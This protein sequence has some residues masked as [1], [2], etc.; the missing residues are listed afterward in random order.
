M[1]DTNLGNA[2]GDDW[3]DSDMFG[4]DEFGETSGVMGYVK[5]AAVGVAGNFGGHLLL[6]SMFTTNPAMAGYAGAAV[7]GVAVGV[8][9]KN[10]MAGVITAAAGVVF[11]FLRPTLKLNGFGLATLGPVPAVHGP[12]TTLRGGFGLPTIAPSANTM[13]MA[14]KMGMNGLGAARGGP[15]LVGDES[16]FGAK[17]ASLVGMGGPSVS[18]LAGHYGATLFGTGR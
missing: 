3:G 11:E 1:S 16:G 13:A 5:H 14:R 18:S 10:V 2:L 12:T 4:L 8:L 15:S 6:S 9:G 7:A 17:A